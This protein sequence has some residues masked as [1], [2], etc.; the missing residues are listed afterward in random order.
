MAPIAC[1]IHTPDFLAIARGYGC[2]ALRVR[3][4]EE[5]AAALSASRQA[6]VPTIIEAREEDFLG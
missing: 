6:D 4:L 5:L 2:E 3:T 1:D